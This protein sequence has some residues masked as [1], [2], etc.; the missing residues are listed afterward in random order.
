M[1]MGLLFIAVV[2]CA[3]LMLS[4]KS[5]LAQVDF[6]MGALQGKLST[7]MWSKPGPGERDT[8]DGGGQAGG[9]KLGRG[10]QLQTLRC[11]S[12]QVLAGAQ[13]RRGD[14]LDFV[15]IACAVP[16]CDAS[17]CRWSRNSLQWGA[18]AGNDA[19]GDEQPP[20]LCPSNSAISGFQAP[21]VTFTIFDYAAGLLIEWWTGQFRT[22]HHLR[23][24][25]A[26]HL[27]S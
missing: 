3:G 15:R 1:R 14:V 27:P 19:G 8:A 9:Q 5:A 10:Y 17:G 16:Y 18:E 12:G 26:D 25:A 13:I 23:D 22:R 7:P 11:A 6:G 2:V 4:A 24:D 20:M 21:V